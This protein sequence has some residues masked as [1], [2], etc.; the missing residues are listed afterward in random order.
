[1]RSRR[2]HLAWLVLCLEVGACSGEGARRDAAVDRSVRTDQLEDAPQ[3]GP[4]DA[5]AEAAPDSAKDSDLEARDGSADRR[6]DLSGDGRRDRPTGDVGT[7][8]LFGTITRSVAPAADA[9]G[10][11]LVGLYLPGIPIPLGG[12]TIAGADLSQPGS[13]V[14]YQLWTVP[15]GTFS[16]VAFLD[17]NNN[18]GGLPIVLADTGD[19]VMSQP[20]TFQS[21]APQRIDLVLDSVQGGLPDGGTGDA[22]PLGAL[23][24]TVTSTAAV[25]GDGRGTLYISLHDQ[26]PPAGQVAWTAVQNANLSSPYASEAY[27]LSSLA[28]GSY[29]LQVFLDDN[30]NNNPFLPGPDKGD[31]VHAKPIQLHIVSGTMEV[32][33]VVLDGAKN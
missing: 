8:P 5:A 3:G 19:L 33:D 27:F 20:A 6:R 13:K 1:M 7:P 17:D 15:A 10:D 4:L 30:L 25:S 28:P 2:L 22:V 11:I 14:D 18:A 23:R 32:Q 12:T 16:L 29:Y 9:R 31:L 26:P 24:G 21:G